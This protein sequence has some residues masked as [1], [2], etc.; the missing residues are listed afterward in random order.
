MANLLAGT[1]QITVDGNSYMLEG[2]AKYSPSTV[3]RTSLVG[4]DGYHGVKEMPVAGS[5]SFTARDAGSL[6]VYDFNRMRNATV[7]LQLANGKT[8]VGRS[9]A[10]VDAQEV[11]TTE[12][13]FDVK[14]EGPLVSEQTAN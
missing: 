4:Q 8:V 13:T 7:V 14:F 11:D 6:T 1:A 2:A 10:C 12:A 3:T 5:I 9:M